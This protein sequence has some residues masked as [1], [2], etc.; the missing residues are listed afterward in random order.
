MAQAGAGSG[1]ATPPGPDN[2]TPGVPVTP[3]AQISS[4]GDVVN[5]FGPTIV[6]NSSSPPTSTAPTG[7]NPLG[8]GSGGEGEGEGDGEGSLS[9]GLACD[10]PPVCEGDAIECAIVQQTFRTRCVEPVDESDLLAATGL[11]GIEEEGLAG[12]T[13]EPVNVSDA[14]DGSGWLS[15]RSCPSSYNVSLGE[16]GG[17]ISVPLSDACWF[18]QAIGLIVLALAYYTAARI[19]VGGF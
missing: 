5:Y 7:G 9:G 8:G 17:S 13:D 2:G 4:L 3:V 19:V 15:G 11:D 14:F 6:N 10:S 12:S 18:F 1:S 16:W